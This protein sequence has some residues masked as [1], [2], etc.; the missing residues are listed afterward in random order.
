MTSNAT[1]E[2]HIPAVAPEDRVP[3]SQK[4]AYGAGAMTDQF[5]VT[6]TKNMFYPVFNIALGISPAIIGTVLMIY[7]LWDGLM[8]L[9]LGNISDN[10]RTRWGRRRPFIVAGG[11]L[12]GLFLPLLWQASPDWS[13]TAI[14]IYMVAAGLLLYTAYA[15]WAMPYY[16]L[17][18]ELTPDYNERT[19]VVAWRAVFS[20]CTVIFGGWLLA[21]AALPAFAD[22]GTGEPNVARGMRAM[23]WVMGAVIIICATLPGFF[24]KERYYEKETKKQGKV[25]LWRG[26]KETLHCGPFLKVMGVYVC[27][28][29]GSNLVASLGLYLNIYYVCGGDQKT[30]YIIQGLK[31]TVIFLPGLFS[32]PFWA[33][34]CEKIGKKGALRITIAMGF[35]TNILVW[36]CYTPA[37]PYLQIVPQVFLSAFG[38]AIWMIV[39]SMQAD[40]VDYDELHTARRREGSFSSVFSW[41]SKLAMTFTTGISGFI[42]VWCGFDKARYG[43]SQPPEVLA[44][45]LRW[46]VFFPMLFWTLAIII[47]HFYPITAGRAKEI[48]RQLEARRGV[49]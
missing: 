23:G 47:L 2:K 18:M 49:V 31:T 1:H 4:L 15:L 33:W 11:V 28:T 27:Q 21:L 44:T 43:A 48:R 38:S 7:R 13:H 42:I 10:A 25:G 26:L 39:P 37:Y 9:L 40:I 16:S 19:R 12:T 30:A 41:T 24:V 46:Y 35:L 20:K 22:P 5:T 36:F 34:V 6:I 45:M 14:I 3:M 17:G 32:V 29:V 8:D